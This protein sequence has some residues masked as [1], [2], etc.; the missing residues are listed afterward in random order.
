[1]EKKKLEVLILKEGGKF[2]AVTS[3]K[4]KNNE[5]TA[6]VGPVLEHITEHIA[7]LATSGPYSELDIRTTTSY[8]D[9]FA[10][11]NKHIAA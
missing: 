2:T 8:K 10:F 3:E 5:L 9:F 6:F 7:R 4:D 11:V 1:M